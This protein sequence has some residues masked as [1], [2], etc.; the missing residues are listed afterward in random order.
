MDD[1]IDLLIDEMKI[2]NNRKKLENDVLNPII[3]HIG[4]QLWPY[5]LSLSIF[6][7]ITFVVLFYTLYVMNKIKI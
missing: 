3:R 2:D 6:M 7:F 4:K 1:V 5:I